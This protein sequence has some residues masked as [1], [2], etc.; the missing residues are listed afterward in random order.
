MF[1]RISVLVSLSFLLS[2]VNQPTNPTLELPQLEELQLLVIQ[3]GYHDYRVL[4]ASPVISSSRIV[5]IE[6]WGRA[7]TTYWGSP[8]IDSLQ[9]TMFPGSL[10]QTDHHEVYFV[11]SGSFVRTLSTK[12]SIQLKFYGESDVLLFSIDTTVS[13]T[14]YPYPSAEIVLT[15]SPTVYGPFQNTV[16]VGDTLFYNNTGSTALF[17]YN[18]ETSIA[19][20]L[21]NYGGGDHLA[22][23]SGYIFIDFGHSGVVRWNTT[24]GTNEGLMLDFS[25]SGNPASQGIMGM[26][27][28]QGQLIL[29][30]RS[31][32]Q[33]TQRFIHR[34]DFRGNIIESVSTDI[35]G[36]YLAIHNDILHTIDF[37]SSRIY[38]HSFGGTRLP[39][40]VK[41]AHNIDGIKFYNGYLYYCDYE[42][43]A[44]G[45]VPMQDLILID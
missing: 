41:P 9:T 23:D 29:I 20:M 24:T 1:L 15:T 28:Y 10:G 30:N 19:T 3:Y 7:D 2:C 31:S 26:D 42:R 11:L 44:L 27:V 22:A 12:E 38:R 43:M 17:R 21:F 39:S 13:T 32:S 40:Y 34:A 18:K 16:F 45:R 6:L 33:L 36:Y 37:G 5:R 8:A 4:P 25:Y 35:P 14:A